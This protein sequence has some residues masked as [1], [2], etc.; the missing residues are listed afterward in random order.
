FGLDTEHGLT[1][2]LAG[3]EDLQ[4]V[5]H[6][7]EI[8]NLDLITCGSIPPNPSELLGSKKME[9]LLLELGK[10][11]D[12]IIIDTPPV[13][14]VTDAVILS[15]KVDGVILVVKAGEANR[16]AVL[17]TKELIES[18]KTSNLI[19]AILNMVETGKTSGYYYYYYHHYGK[20]DKY[21]GDKAKQ[22]GKK[23]QTSTSASRA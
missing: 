6:K 16:N 22:H 8:P 7:T 12:R 21:Y 10:C 4:K 11:Y 20:Y 19:G 15:A 3:T 2:V 1:E 5:I 13:L 14:A 18:M 9:E 17:K 23:E